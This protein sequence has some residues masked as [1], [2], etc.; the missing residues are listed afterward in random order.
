MTRITIEMPEQTPLRDIFKFA[1][2]QGCVIV[3]QADG[4]FRMEPHGNRKPCSPFPAEVPPSGKIARLPT[5][6]RVV[7]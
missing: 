5:H 6:L 4:S 2:S 7:E 1:A 3:H